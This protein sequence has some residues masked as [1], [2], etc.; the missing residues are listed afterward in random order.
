LPLVL[1]AAV[2]DSSA[3]AGADAGT[4]GHEPVQ[5]SECLRSLEAGR[6]PYVASIHGD[7]HHS[8]KTER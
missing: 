8:G 6:A 5:S 7:G 3:L 4:C 1:R 2:L